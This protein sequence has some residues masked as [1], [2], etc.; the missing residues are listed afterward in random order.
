MDDTDLHDLDEL[1]E[2]TAERILEALLPDESSLVASG[3]LDAPTVAPLPTDE[4]VEAVEQI[5]LEAQYAA[6]IA[7]LVLLG[8]TIGEATGLAGELPTLG[9]SDP[10]RIRQRL[11]T[12]RQTINVRIQDAYVA[13]IAK[14]QSPVDAAKQAR[15]AVAAS[16]SRTAEA[17]ALGTV[18]GGID[19]L[20]GFLAGEGMS[21]TKTWFTRRDA[22]VRLDHIQAEGQEVPYSQSFSIGGW[23]M[24]YPGDVRAPARLWANCR[25]IM[26]LNRK[27]IPPSGS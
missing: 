13:A 27:A 1:L 12:L 23:P 24:Q 22:R 2:Q 7:M 3:V 6:V 9:A 8:L 5:E 11:I 20:G 10:T 19:L 21:V 25:C 18:N 15:N 16:L 26:V 14:G 17:E 4:E